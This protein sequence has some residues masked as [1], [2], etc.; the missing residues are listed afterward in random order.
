MRGDTGARGALCKGVHAVD[1]GRPATDPVLP[2]QHWRWRGEAVR[3]DGA[4]SA[5]WLGRPLAR[6]DI[7]PRARRRL[8]RLALA[9]PS[10]TLDEGEPAPP[11]GGLLLTDGLRLFP[12][13]LVAAG[14]RVTIVFDPWLPPAET[15]L[16]V[17]A[18]AEPAPAAPP[19]V[20]GGIVAGTLVATDTGPRQ[21]ETLDPGDLVLTRD[22]GLQPVVWRGETR[23][24][25]A[26]LTAHP[27]L[28]PCRIATGAGAL[29]LAPG[30]RLVVPALPGLGGGAEALARVGDLEDGQRIRRELGGQLAGQ[31][32]V[33]VQ[34]M[35]PGHEIL[36][37]QGL[38]SE[39]FHPA[40][41]DPV[42][43]RWHARGLER[44]APGLTSAP[45][46]FGDPALRCLNRAE[47]ALL[48]AA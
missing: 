19:P 10:P 38:D 5:L 30:H 1:W 4:G 40:L 18:C 9:P 12:A 27:H 3:L 29:R 39:S 45:H 47:A 36:T 15:D 24:S 25:G 43:L 20:P 32:V 37:L 44:A 31:T 33:Y 28:R 48:A 34:L 42:A 26:E 8:D 35:L 14:A 11:P 7:R 2:G 23:L 21:I 13:R 41:A 17:A 6:A 22:N 46:Q 16:W